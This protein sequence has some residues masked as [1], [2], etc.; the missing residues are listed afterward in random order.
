MVKESELIHQLGILATQLVKCKEI[1]EK[2]EHILY[3]LRTIPH[4]T[5]KDGS[6]GKTDNS[7]NV[8]IQ[9]PKGEEFVLAHEYYYS[10]NYAHSKTIDKINGSEELR[11]LARQPTIVQLAYLMQVYGKPLKVSAFFNNLYDWEGQDVINENWEI[12]FE[13]P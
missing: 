5:Y 11:H 2:K 3:I 10:S 4:E 12:S 1:S 9:A 7:L 6:M 8:N 13:F